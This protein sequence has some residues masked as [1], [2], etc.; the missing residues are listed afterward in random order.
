[1]RSGFYPGKRHL[2]PLHHYYITH[3]VAP[4]L[5]S[6]MALGL[7]YSLAAAAAASTPGQL[8]RGK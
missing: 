1:M 7:P 4:L 6:P 8:L 3:I 2:L 5:A